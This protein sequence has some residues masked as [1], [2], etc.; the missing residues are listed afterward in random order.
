MSLLPA[1]TELDETTTLLAKYL[2]APL[3]KYAWGWEQL[4][5]WL[6]D[7]LAELI[8]TDM[9]KVYYY[10]YRVDVSETRLRRALQ[11]DPQHSLSPIMLADLMLE[12]T[13]EKARTRIAYRQWQ[14]SQSSPDPAKQQAPN[15]LAD[16]W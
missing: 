14:Q 11:A 16:E 8:A 3:D 13:L 4:R 1:P 10:L 6:I 12:R 9:A 2:E 5:Q 7:L 15:E